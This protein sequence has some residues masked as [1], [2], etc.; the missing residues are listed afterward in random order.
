MKTHIDT[1]RA[2]A[3]RAARIDTMKASHTP[4]PWV[5]KDSPKYTLV[6]IIGG[7]A[8]RIAKVDLC[9][10]ENPNGKWIPDSSQTMA[11]ARLIAS[12]PDLLKALQDILAPL[13]EDDYVDCW[14]YQ[15]ARNAIAKAKG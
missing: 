15:N 9:I 12:A 1:L 14:Q 5:I 4:G 10:N 13:G 3:E 2:G 7:L 11:N 6:E 8:D